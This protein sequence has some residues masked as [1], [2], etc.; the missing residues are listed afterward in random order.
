MPKTI[1]ITGAS[2]GIGKQAA[3]YFKQQ[4]HTVIGVSRE[5][6]KD[7]SI[8]YIE[9]DLSDKSSIISATSQIKTQYDRIDI[10]IN[11]AGVGTGGA[12]EDTSYE[13]LL[14]V[15]KVNVLGLMEFTK[16]L[17]P[18][19]KQSKDKKIINIGSVAGEFT[20]P[21]QVSYSMSK[22]SIE[23]FTEGLRLELKPYNIQVTTVLPGDTKTHFT[24][25]R[26]ITNKKDSPYFKRAKHSLDK[27][28]TDETKGVKPQ[29]VVDVIAR[30]IKKKRLPIYKVVGWQ[31]K[32]LVF[33]KR[34]IPGK[35]ISVIIYKLYG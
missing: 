30:L 5:K 20:I 6:P 26:I 15:Y 21:F 4:G 16:Q 27:M 23:R 1:L 18:L 17:L 12:I 31:Y 28:N 35:W 29:K 14:L 25:N 24:N 10:L 8:P 9:C 32:L 2:S 34:F 3:I 13:D 22:S 11:N 7:L 33:L 19:I